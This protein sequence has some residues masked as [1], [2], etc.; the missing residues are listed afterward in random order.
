MYSDKDHLKLTNSNSGTIIN[1]FNG[2]KCV[3]TKTS[4]RTILLKCLNA[5]SV[6]LNFKNLK[7]SFPFFFEVDILQ[8]DKK[9]IVTYETGLIDMRFDGI[10]QFDIPFIMKEINLDYMKKAYIRVK[11]LTK[12]GKI[13]EESTQKISTQLNCTLNFGS[14]GEIQLTEKL[15]K[16]VFAKKDNCCASFRSL[17]AFML[18]IENCV[19]FN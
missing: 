18:H 17:R 5:L 14:Y 11:I 1:I 19:Y 12:S 15:I 10:K 4:N 2:I 16:C 9:A 6:L 13:K 7:V 3:T 8:N